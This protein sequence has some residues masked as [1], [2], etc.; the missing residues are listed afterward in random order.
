[1]GISKAQKGLFLKSDLD[2]SFGTKGEKGTGIGLMLS[3]EF[4]KA[5][6]GRIWVE[7]EEEKGATFYF[8]FPQH[9][10]ISVIE[11]PEHIEV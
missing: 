6:K 10:S 7:S 8:T 2:V 4:I 9:N 11:Q 5:N 1:L 3:K